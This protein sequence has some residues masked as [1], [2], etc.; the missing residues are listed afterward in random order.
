MSQD[1]RDALLAL[2]RSDINGDAYRK[3]RNALKK[4]THVT[5]CAVA[6]VP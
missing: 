1:A 4:T 5:A 2:N 6:F 3:A